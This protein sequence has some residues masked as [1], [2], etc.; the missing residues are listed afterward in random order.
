[1]A[2]AEDAAAPAAVGADEVGHVLNYAEHALVHHPGHVHGLFNYHADELLRARDDYHA[3]HGQGLEHGQRDV[4]RPGGHVDEHVVHIV[5]HDVG[6]ELL[7]RAGDDRPAPDH[8]VRLVREQDV[9]AHHLYAGGAAHG[10]YE[11][12][13]AARHLVYAEHLR[14]AGAGDVRVEDSGAVA[15]ALHFG[16]EQAGDKAL[17]D[18]ALAADN[19][20][21][22][23]DGA[24]VM[25][26]LQE[27]LLLAAGAVF[28]AGGAIAG[29]VFV[30]FAHW[31]LPSLDGAINRREYFI[32]SAILYN[33]KR[34]LVNIRRRPGRGFR[35][36]GGTSPRSPKPAAGFRRG[37]TP[38]CS[39]AWQILL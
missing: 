14:H 12:L 4:A 2:L 1:M 3:V 32:A 23:P 15:A 31:L 16:G 10:Q 20:D 17:S 9:H 35:A 21:D 25:Q 7:Y 37:R 18:P 36:P 19:G 24:A 8:G 26:R 28:P 27:A 39:P 30:I 13:P 29:A 33:R 6:P 38:P 34:Q 11:I 5:P 22:A